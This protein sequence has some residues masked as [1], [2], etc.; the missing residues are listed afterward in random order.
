MNKAQRV[1]L[2]V[3]LAFTVFSLFFTSLYRDSDP[4]WYFRFSLRLTMFLTVLALMKRSREHVLIMLALLSSVVSD[5]Y[6]LL[7]LTFKAE[8]PNRQIYGMLGFTLTYVFLTAAFSHQFRPGK[9]EALTLVPFG[10]TFLLVF[11]QLRPYVRGIMF[12]A[13]L[14]LGVI[15]CWFAMTMVSVLYRKTYSRKIAWLLALAGV[16]AFASDMVVAFTLFHPAFNTFIEWVQNFVWGTYMTA[17]T[18]LVVVMADDQHSVQKNSE[19]RSGEP[20]GLPLI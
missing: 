19:S 16:I 3:F 9:K 15:L 8:I 5:Y 12:P 18:L 20:R 11:L 6:F 1:L 10:L 14:V 2:A 4:V 17:W 7:A 13:A